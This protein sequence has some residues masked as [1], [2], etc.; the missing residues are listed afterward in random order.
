MP[1][2]ESKNRLSQLLMTTESSLFRGSAE[3]I[4]S[5]IRREINQKRSMM[6]VKILDL[7]CGGR[8]PLGGAYE[9]GPPRFLLLT[10]SEGAIGTGIDLEDYP[11]SKDIYRHIQA[12]LFPYLLEDRDFNE[13]FRGLPLEHQAPFDLIISTNFVENPTND[14]L[15]FLAARGIPKQVLHDKF[16]EKAIKLGR[17]GSLVATSDERF[18][19]EDGQLVK[20]ST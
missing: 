17:N 19:I 9:A 5:H 3:A 12:D 2:T 15:R 16:L 1:D 14:M 6:G 8:I 13:L 4:L 20:I 18:R 11:D 10:V 7:A